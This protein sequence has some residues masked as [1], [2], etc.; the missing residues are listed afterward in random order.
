MHAAAPA[1]H[2]TGQAGQNAVLACD[3]AAI[4]ADSTA[5]LAF[6]DGARVPCDRFIMRCFSGVVR[7]LLEDAVCDLDVR[8]RSIIP[9]PTQASAPYWD[10]VDVMHG[11]ASVWAMNAARLLRVARC[12]SFLEVTAYESTIDARLWGLLSTAPFGEFVA[13]MSRF[14]RNAGLA[15]LAVMRAIQHRPLWADFRRDVLGG[16]DADPAVTA[17]VVHFAPNF[18]PP[19]LVAAWALGA[20]A[21]PRSLDEALK[22]VSHHGV[23]YHPCETLAVLR[24]VAD[25]VNALETSEGVAGLKRLLR[26]TLLA[27]DTYDTVPWTTHRAHGSVLMYTDTPMASVSIALEGGRLPSRIRAARWLTVLLWPDGRFD[28]H[29]Q[30]RRIDD[31]AAVVADRMQLRI[32]ALDAP[33]VP[34]SESAEAWYLFELAFAADDPQGAHNGTYTLAHHTGRQG[35]AA[36]IN[37]MLRGGRAR[38]LRFDFFY[39][40]CSVLER[41]FDVT[42]CHRFVSAA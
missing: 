11:S 12:M 5:V 40:A 27:T 1:T 30:P 13:Q 17:A 34:A 25:T 35:D 24:R 10:A 9:L 19:A 20:R 3:R 37:D 6:D 29:F 36:A 32:M 39:G 21:T 8:G 42:K 28:L 26:M 16:L 22:L 14:L 2:A 15:P 31:V 23:M 41:P 7:R 33:G 4:D 18:F 38:Q